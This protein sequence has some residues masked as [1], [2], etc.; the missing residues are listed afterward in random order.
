LFFFF[1]PDRTILV[2][3]TSNFAFVFVQ[4][5][6]GIR[7]GVTRRRTRCGKYDQRY[8][9]FSTLDPK[10]FQKSSSESNSHRQTRKQCERSNETQVSACLT[11]SLY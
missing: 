5:L 4:M 11:I 3:F 1:L 10:T 7:E 2:H 9:F 6:R 8:I